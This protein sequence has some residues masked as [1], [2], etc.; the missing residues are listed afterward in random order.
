V[1]QD[2]QL[3]PPNEGADTCYKQLKDSSVAQW[4]EK[5]AQA[6]RSTECSAYCIDFRVRSVCG[7]CVVIVYSECAVLLAGMYMYKNMCATP[8][9]YDAQLLSVLECASSVMNMTYLQC[10]TLSTGFNCIYLIAR[11]AQTRLSTLSSKHD[12]QRSVHAFQAL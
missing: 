1:I 4:Y 11:L 3:K 2:V 9:W 7:H 8:M 10:A 6:K 5:A 12:C